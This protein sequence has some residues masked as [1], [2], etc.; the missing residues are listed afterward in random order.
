MSHFY[1]IVF[2]KITH[3]LSLIILLILQFMQILLCIG[4]IFSLITPQFINYGILLV[5]L[6][7]IR[8]I[9]LCTN[10]L[11]HS[12]TPIIKKSFLPDDRDLLIQELESSLKKFS[13]FAK[14]ICGILATIIALTVTISVN[15][16]MKG[17]DLIIDAIPLNDLSEEIRSLINNSDSIFQLLFLITILITSFILLPYFTLQLF[18]YNK[19]LTLKILKS[20]K[21]KHD[22]PSYQSY[23]FITFIKELLFLDYLI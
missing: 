15:L 20:C 21:Y 8:G 19:R 23:T 17:F 16:Y 14:W 5:Y 10:Y 12:L 9:H 1:S 4:L 22:Y 11:I 13:D 2:K 7:F 3:K 6:L 18:T